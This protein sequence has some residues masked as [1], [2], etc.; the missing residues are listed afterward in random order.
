SLQR[1]TRLHLTGD[2]LYEDTVRA[3]I[4]APAFSRLSHLDLTR[5]VL[6]DSGVPILLGWTGL[7]G[8]RSLR[9]QGILCGEDEDHYELAECPH[10]NRL[11]F[12]DLRGTLLRD[13]AVRR[14][15]QS[16]SLAGL[17]GL[18]LRGYSFITSAGWSAL[19]GSPTLK[20][21]RWLGVN[22]L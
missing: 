20:Q 3:L 4:A 16:E 22:F 18:D 13:E 14:L 8:L 7:S 17:E 5:S 11:K 6:E 19:A 21:L 10:L 12:L 2:N 1:V 15:A 9:C